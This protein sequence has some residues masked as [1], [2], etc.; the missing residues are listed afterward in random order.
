MR[1]ADVLQIRS[2]KPL[3]RR[4]I[5]ASLILDAGVLVEAETDLSNAVQLVEILEQTGLSEQYS[6][7]CQ[8]ERVQHR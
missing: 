2:M 4:S 5:C 3:V 7:R 1:P 6:V 8:C